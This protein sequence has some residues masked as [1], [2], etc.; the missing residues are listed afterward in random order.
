MAV[1]NSKG[2]WQARVLRK[3]RVK[4][5]QKRQVPVIES[6]EPRILLSAD[7]PGL[8]A[9]DVDPNDPLDADVDQIL[10][11]AYDAFQTIERDSAD[12]LND[13]VKEAGVDEP[14]TALPS[15][16][17]TDD[18]RHELI[19]VD[20]SV[21][22]YERLLADVSAVNGQGTRLEIVMIDPQRNGVEQI[23]QMLVT[24]SGLAAIHL[25]SH[26][27]DGAIRIGV[28]ELDLALLQN[29]ADTFSDWGRALGE[30]AD[31][32]IYGCD[33]AKTGSGQ[34]L[35]S[36]LA[37]LTGADIAASIDLTGHETLGG[38]WD[39][40]YRSGDIETDI[41]VTQNAR[42]QWQ[43]TLDTTTGLIGHWAFDTDGAD[44]S[45]S[46]YDGTLTGSATIDTSAGNQAVGSGALSLDGSDVQDDYLELSAYAATLGTLSEGT[47]SGWINTS[48]AVRTQ[49]LFGISD[50]SDNVVQFS[51]ASFGVYQGHLFYDVAEQGSYLQDSYT[52]AIVAD[53][54]WHH[55]ALTVDA[56]GNSFYIDGVKVDSADINYGSGGPGS[57][58]FFNSVTDVDT[59][60]IGVTGERGGYAYDFNGLIDDVRI[61]DRALSTSDIAELAGYNPLTVTSTADNNDAG[62]VD[63][64][65]GHDISWLVANQGA[66]SRISLREAIIA[67]N[68]TANFDGSTPDEIHFE[69]TD[70]LGGNGAHTINVSAGGLPGITDLVIIDGTTDGDFGGTPIVEINGGL[71]G[72]GVDGLVLADGSDGSTV[73]GLVI[74]SFNGDGIQIDSGADGNTIA[75]NYIGI[76]VDGATDLGNTEIGVRIASAGNVVGGTLTADRNVISGNDAEGIRIETLS[77]TGNAII[78]NYVGLDAGG[79]LDVGNTQFGVRVGT[80]NNKVGGDQVAERNVISG[81]DLANV[82]VVSGSTT[83]VKVQGNYIGSDKDGN[84]GISNVYGV[85]LNKSAGNMIG[86]TRPGEGNLIVGNSIGIHANSNGA[87]DNAFLGNSID[88]SNGQAIDLG[89]SFGVLPNDAEDTDT[90]P[91]EGINFPVLTN[92]V[93][94]GADLNVDF[95]VDLP[96][97]QYRIE[98][99]DNPN[100]LGGSGF[101]PGEQFVGYAH[102]TVTGAVGYESFS[103]TLTGV[104]ASNILSIA[105]TA[106]E[107]NTTFTTFASTSEFGPQFLGAG[108]IEVTTASDTSDGDTSS[109]A[110]LLGNRGAD[111]EISL[112]E[113]ILATNNTVGADT[114]NFGIAGA[115][116]HV[117]NLASALPSIT[118]TVTIDGSSEPDYAANTPVVRIDGATAGGSASGITF[119]GTSDGSTLRGLMVTRFT[120]DGIVVQ[121]G[122]DGIT[123]AGNWIG[124]SGTGSTGVG[125]ADDGIDLRG[126][127]AIIGGTGPSDR[128]VIT[129]SGDEGVDIVGAGVTGHLI[130]GNFIGVDPDG[131]TGGGNADVGIAI[132]SGSGNTIGGATPEARNVISMNLEGIEINTSNNV[133]QGNY[134]G[135][136]ASG[137]LDRGNRSDDGVEIQGS[138]TGNTIGGT[139]AGAGNLISGNAGSGVRIVGGS[140]HLVSG[141]LIGTDITGSTDLGNSGVGV[142]LSGTSN[143]VI[144]GTTSDGRNVIS[145]NDSHG[146]EVAGATTTGNVILGNYIGTNAAGMAG[147]RN[148]GNGIRLTTNQSTTVG[149]TTAGA[150]NVI[151]GNNNS[152]TSADGIYITGGGSHTV[153]GNNIGLGADGSMLLG[154][155]SSGVAISSSTNNLIGGATAAARNVISGNTLGVSIS[156]S[157]TGN[158]VQGNYIGTD[159]TGL[160][161]RGN[162]SDGLVISGGAQYNTIGGTT[163]NHRNIISGNDNDGIWITGAGT[164]NNTVQGNWIGVDAAG[165]TLGNSYHG[166]GVENGA[167]DNLI[168]G[169][170][171]GAGNTISNNA[172]DGVAVA[173]GTGDGNSLLANEISGNTGLGIDHNNDGVTANDSNDLDTGPNNLQ[174]FPVIDQA[175]LFGTDLTLSGKLGTDGL[176]TSYR[177][178]FFGGTAG[179]Q[180]S[181]HGEGR[182]YLG[183]TIVTTD[184]SGEASFSAITLSGVTLAAG[185][186]VTA[187]ATRIDSLAQVGV[188][189]AL[190]YGSTSEFSANVAIVGTNSAPTIESTIAAQNINE[191]FAGYTIDLNAAF[192]DT[193]TPDGSLVYSVTG[194]TNINVSIA[195]G[196]ATITPTAD[197]NGSETLTFTSTDAGGLSVSQVVGFAVTAVDDIAND[198]AVSVIEDTATIITVLGND[199][200]EGTPVVTAAS[201]PSNGSVVINGDN[202]ITYTPNS[203]YTGA[204]SFTY[205]VTSGGVTETATVTLNVIPVNDAPTVEGTIAAQNINEDFAS[206]TIDLNA[207]FAD[208]ETPDGA[209]VY[210]VTGNTNINVSIASG[211][212]TITPTADW[213]GSETLTFTATDGGGLSVSQVVGFAVTAVDDIADDS[214]V[215]VTEDTA[216]IITVLGNDSFEG[217]PVVTATGSPSNGSVVINGDNTITYTPSLNYNGADSFTY[218]VTSGGVTETAT[219][220]LNVTAVNNLPTISGTSIGSVTEDDDPDGDGLLEAAGSLTIV[221]PDPG[222]SYFAAGTAVGTHGT[223]IID[224]SGNWNYE[225]VNAQASIQRLDAGEGV[226]DIFTV[227]TADGTSHSVTVTINGGEDAAVVSGNRNGSVTE[228]G[229]LNVN[230]QL[231]IIDPDSA[232][233]PVDFPDQVS[234]Q[235][236][237]GFGTFQLTAG[238]WSY[239][240]NNGHASVQSL[241]SG[242]SL[243]DTHTFRASDGTTQQVRIVIV[244]ETEAPPPPVFEPRSPEPGPERADG[245]ER[246]PQDEED[247]ITS[248][249]EKD[250]DSEDGPSADDSLAGRTDTS[251]GQAE[252]AEPFVIGLKPLFTEPLEPGEIFLSVLAAPPSID[253]PSVQKTVITAAKPTVEAA[254]TFLQDLKS[255]WQEESATTSAEMSGTRLSQTFW[256]GVDKMA[257]DLDQ[258]IEEQDRKMQLSAEAAAGLGISLTAGFVSWALRAGSMAA[259][260]LAAM[261]SWRNF[262]PMPVLVA[263]DKARRGNNEGKDE[264]PEDEDNDAKVDDLFED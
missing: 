51:L 157:S 73:R 196:I 149:G 132:I 161:D 87:I 216:T 237:N 32:L 98:F 110:A 45:A 166:I 212:A 253:A 170:A 16:E 63:G 159:A 107:A 154:N 121:S 136:D 86:G 264:L 207:A 84:A 69:I 124:T 204:D 139:V 41:V 108:V 160:L 238:N 131:S 214:A 15:N 190:A 228:D 85:A 155:Y 189:D 13:S 260:F 156:G 112:R 30:G 168:G 244:G 5:K 201:A 200:F 78:G 58:T 215:S 184:G 129:N 44:S 28:D 138:S 46:G 126:T 162:T 153:Q 48:D 80:T 137:T 3:K 213:N 191:D 179:T 183:A 54:N 164:D 165:G 230:G 135:T 208:T 91:N 221:D 209:L 182:Y 226:D 7:F 49:T 66:D 210:G 187:T 231:R 25:I 70:P 62:I 115:G 195:A 117:I 130:Q 61:Y 123:I 150:G 252:A 95:K 227:T 248:D 83:G 57:S 101:G 79:T 206:Y 71:A 68:N 106:T 223:L 143:N 134:I 185:D 21:P 172:W 53:G 67:A 152:G 34:E 222:E 145:G 175:D 127:G 236:D 77:A 11:R 250:S 4:K 72:A 203:N 142:Y 167:A 249:M 76:G 128:N 197:W 19:I 133:V 26:G 148:E 125:N 50:H 37:E 12:Q 109:I 20:P 141:N 257:D 6:L 56:T 181:T 246:L 113:A 198:N 229:T 103:A 256:S 245:I 259:S 192:A 173:N 122:A 96:A 180:D 171:T 262:D 146:V 241:G 42:L 43:A 94:N 242:E 258:S 169:T 211:I 65:L 234:T 235:G 17:T 119:T 144:G 36:S 24:R 217:T 74:N 194:N 64:N 102:I 31:I 255:F 90:G 18:V 205:T 243:I 174:N 251:T 199:S 163:G 35:V 147:V 92:V 116:T 261:P 202:T 33:V 9:P 140:G 111:G 8:D 81:N 82:Y 88:S 176:S 23:T 240:L 220:T 233:N 89:P 59:V 27:S 247:D 75:G 188:D 151:S 100:G 52:D 47:V 114:I 224:A 178:E 2:S 99:F 60:Q 193:E 186:Y 105:A 10:A 254:Q 218:T 97:G 22:D 1:P 232:D 38:D 39:L 239:T 29:N 263:D 93:Q 219:V 225:T 55:V 104:T 14:D 158:D 177:I 120:V 118:D 40:E